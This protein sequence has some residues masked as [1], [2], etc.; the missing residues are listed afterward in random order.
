MKNPN[1]LTK[2]KIQAMQTRRNLFQAAK[3][4]FMEYGYDAVSVDD[5]VEKAGMSKGAFYAHFVSKDQIILEQFSEIDEYYWKVYEEEIKHLPSAEEQLLAFVKAQ[6]TYISET[7]GLSFI[8]TVYASQ[9]TTRSSQRPFSNENRP[10]Y[11]IIQNIV[12]LGQEQGE[13]RKDMKPI[14]VARII[15]RCM[16]GTIYD[17]C[18]QE[19]DFELV[20]SGLYFFK[21]VING[22]KSRE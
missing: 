1:K 11:L 5:I 18:V 9:I 6:L 3:Q 2:R 19:G 16:R 13:F 14:E 17:W 22:L 8:K 7:M 4:L 20:E 21:V 15:T 10:L 12:S